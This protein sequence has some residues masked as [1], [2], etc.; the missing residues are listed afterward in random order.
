MKFRFLI[1]ENVM[2]MEERINRINELARKSRVT[3]LTAE[4]K[5]EQA[6]LRREYIDNI[7]GNL[8]VQLESIEFVDSDKKPD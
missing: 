3:K 7:K 8:R 4:E 5:A 1:G 6:K 2:T